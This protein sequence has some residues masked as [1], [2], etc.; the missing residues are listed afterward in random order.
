MRRF[1]TENIPAVGGQVRLSE[2]VSHH[3]LRVT[4]I[5]PGEAV[6]LFDGA[7]RACRAELNHVESGRACLTVT[8]VVDDMAS[9]VQVDLVLAQTRASTMDTVLRMATELGVRSVRV[10]QAERCVAKG[11]KRDRWTRIVQAAA[12]Q[13]GRSRVPEVTAPEVLSSVLES[14]EGARLI[15]APGAAQLPISASSVTILIGPEGGFSD[16]ELADAEAH[17]W[18]IAGLGGTV[19]RADTA[20]IA[21]IV[22]YG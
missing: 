4:G 21:A 20:A 18:S 3:L 8:Q 16:A 13:S 15:C 10:V 22:R 17:G 19:L 11:D 12:A 6:E 14:V 1:L 9:G 5:A 7:G 2:E